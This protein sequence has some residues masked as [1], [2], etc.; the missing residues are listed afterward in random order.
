MT[1][2]THTPV[3]APEVFDLLSPALNAPQNGDG[4]VFYDCTLGLG[5]HSAYFLERLPALTVV[6]IDRDSA[7]LV[8]ASARLKELLAA[9]D[10]KEFATADLSAPAVADLK[11]FASLTQERAGQF[12]TYHGT[13]DEID[14]AVAETGLRPDAVLMDLGVSSMQLDDDSRGFA[15]S[16]DVPLDM[17]MNADSGETAADLIASST[18]DEL[19]DIFR[20]YGEERFSAGVAKSVKAATPTS[21]GELADAVRRGLP[22]AKR[23]GDQG[24]ASIK[25]VF[26][27]LRVAVNGE[28]D[29]I[30]QALPKAVD[31]L[32]QGGRIAI[33]SY[34][35]LEDK[36]VKSFFAGRSREGRKPPAGLEKLPIDLTDFSGADLEL[37]TKGALK[38][39]D[40]EVEVNPRA[41][42][43]RM[44]VARKRVG[45]SF[46]ADAGSKPAANGLAP[47]APNNEFAGANLGPVY[48]GKGLPVA[49]TD[50]TPAALGPVYTGKGGST[51]GV[52]GSRA[53][54]DHVTPF[55]ADAPLPL[56]PIPAPTAAVTP[57]PADA[58]SKPEG[59]RTARAEARSSDGS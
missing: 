12:R 15:Y 11:E 53:Q 21:T 14:S 13:F 50:G 56:P 55:P 33:M 34:H 51:E 6:G 31:A 19:A 44:R 30:E 54:L 41:K 37:V 43:V 23:Q 26:Q 47:L 38:A 25:R 48:T 28:L 1:N 2:F 4:K 32:N 7:A 16:R 39:T 22:A 46:P 36:A 58:G 59:L 5:G 35:S 45:D 40:A 24:L 52:A 20:R 8:H 42:S 27:A 29:S 10:L 49:L 17:R 3:L 18:A 57:F 9:A